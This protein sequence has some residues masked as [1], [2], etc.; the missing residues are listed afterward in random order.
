[1]DLQ[2]A[3][4]NAFFE[5]PDEEKREV[6]FIPGE[7]QFGYRIPEEI[8]GT[9]I[10]ENIELLNVHKFIPGTDYPRHAFVRQ[11]ERTISSFQKLVHDAVISKLLILFAIM[12]ELPEDNF[13]AMH[14]FE[15][16]SDEHLRYVSASDLLN[17]LQ[18]R[19]P[20]EEWKW[21]KY[22]P[23]AIVCNAA[24]LL[25]MMTKG[26][27]KSSIHRVVRPPAD[28]NHLARLGVFYFLRPTD[29]VRIRIRLS[30]SPVLGRAGLWDLEVD[31]KA[32]GE[33]APTCGEFV[34]ARMKNFVPSRIMG[35]DEKATTRVGNLEVVNKY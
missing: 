34:L 16:P 29:D 32:R 19:T 24:D 21:V 23:G 25:S 35:S 13:T 20:E 7:T 17:S 33:D 8:H 22:V 28:Q 27:I 3:L 15:K 10:K 18:I 9:G 12:L 14:R 31:E 6:V 5:L 26:Y 1:M 30:Y 2:F 11:H 4:A